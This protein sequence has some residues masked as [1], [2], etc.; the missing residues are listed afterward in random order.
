MKGNQQKKKKKVSVIFSVFPVCVYFVLLG[1]K[2]YLYFPDWELE[3]IPLTKVKRH[4][5]EH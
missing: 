5:H 1:Y 3:S 4:I 2:L